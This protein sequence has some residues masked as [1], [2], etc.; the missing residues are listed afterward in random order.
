M[1]HAI[2]TRYI[3]DERVPAFVGGHSGEPSELAV[4]TRPSSVICYVQNVIPCAIMTLIQRNR[5]LNR[6]LSREPTQYD[7]QTVISESCSSVFT[8]CQPKN[9]RTT[10][11]ITI[12]DNAVRRAQICYPSNNLASAAARGA[13]CNHRRSAGV[14][15]TRPADVR[16]VF[17]PHYRTGNSP[18][19]SQG[20]GHLYSKLSF[21]RRAEL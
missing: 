3:S 16:N 11:H 8:R 9:T 7:Q 18:A 6:F 12:N 5:V 1:A 4:P 10:G 20:I 2:L 19:D 17:I 14:R 21:M 15:Q 13:R